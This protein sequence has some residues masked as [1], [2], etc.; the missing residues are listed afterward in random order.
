MSSESSPLE[1]SPITLESNLGTQTMRKFTLYTLK[2]NCQITQT[3]IFIS[4]LPLHSRCPF[5]LSFEHF[6]PMYH[7][8]FKLNM[9]KI[10]MHHLGP[11]TLLSANPFHTMRTRKNF[12]TWGT[13]SIHVT[14]IQIFAVVVEFQNNSEEAFLSVN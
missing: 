1:N 5:Q 13:G 12:S 3:Q 6:F 11:S 4:K 2:S 10:Q 7:R 14:L 9:L 8:Y